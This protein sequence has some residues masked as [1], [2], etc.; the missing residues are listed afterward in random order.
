MK[1]T[2]RALLG[3]M[4][5]LFMFGSVRAEGVGSDFSNVVEIK[6]SALQTESILSLSANSFSVGAWVKEPRLAPAN[7]AVYIYHT[8]VAICRIQTDEDELHFMVNQNGEWVKTYATGVTRD[9]LNDGQW[10]FVCT[11]FNYDAGNV[12][13][14]KQRIY[15]D[16]ILKAES[17]TTGTV[18]APSYK[19]T[20]CARREYAGDQ[21][22]TKMWDSGR[23]GELTVWNRSLTTVEVETLYAHVRVGGNENGLV[24][25]WPMSGSKSRC[26]NYSTSSARAEGLLVSPSIGEAT[27]VGDSELLNVRYVASPEWIAAHGYVK[28]TGATFRSLDDPA[29]SIQEAIDATSIGE[30]VRVLP[31]VYPVESTVTMTGKRLTLESYNPE[32]K[33]PDRAGTVLDGQ[34]KVRVLYCSNG[35]SDATPVDLP[36]LVRGLTIRNGN[37]TS[38]N[39]SVYLRGDATANGG[40]SQCGVIANC[41]F[42]NC[43]TQMA[44]GA[45]Y[46][47]YGGIV[48]NCIFRSNHAEQGGAI[49]YY[50]PAE[51]FGTYEKTLANEASVPLIC[52]CVFEANT[53]VGDVNGGGGAVSYRPPPS[54]RENPTY[55]AIIRRCTFKDNTC[56]GRGGAVSLG[57]NSVIESCLFTGQSGSCYCGTVVDMRGRSN[58]THALFANNTITGVS[59]SIAEHGLIEMHG[60]GYTIVNCMVTNNSITAGSIIRV[61]GD[62]TGGLV[63]QCLFADNGEG[64]GVIRGCYNGT[65]RFEN[66]T[67]DGDEGGVFLAPTGTQRIELVNTVVRSTQ[68]IVSTETKNFVVKN[69]VLP[70]VPGGV[71]DSGVIAGDPSFTD[72]A[73]GNY[74]PRRSSPC[75]DAALPLAWMTDARDLAGAPRVVR[76]GVVRTDN[77]YA[78]IGCFENGLKPG[79]LVIFFS[80][81]GLR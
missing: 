48:S 21:W 56:Q 36:F 43:R 69:C 26:A 17:T 11:T 55:P 62:G 1:D 34:N 45:V 67:I 47:V 8:D 63:R 64:W 52:D 49:A 31:G 53:A 7:D 51:T 73:H 59:C 2:T 81:C 54:E 37:H 18:K 61:E 80:S 29:T 50:H 76:D 57:F 42:E 23:I 71:E 65:V 12:S 25:W 78:D 77:L 46:V 70:N 3:G 16:G 33:A 30:T 79:G 72:A 32:T 5:A 14:S 39:G 22:I 66:C 68:Q 40:V 15:V 35:A 41:L 60:I 24:Y 4:T 27:I 9:T 38:G 28:P 20:F 6:G 10:H 75:R 13:V 44:G 58:G 74:M 19:L